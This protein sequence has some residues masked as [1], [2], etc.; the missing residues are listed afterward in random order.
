MPAPELNH[1]SLNDPGLNDPGLNNTPAAAF[2]AQ[3]LARMAKAQPIDTVKAAP[4]DISLLTRLWFHLR[5]HANQPL[6]AAH[7]N[8]NTLTA[9][10]A[11]HPAYAAALRD[12][13]V[14]LFATKQSTRL[15]TESGLLPY[16]SFSAALKR[17]IGFK[18]LPPELNPNHPRDW[19]DTHFIPRDSEWVSAAD[20]A[21]WARLCELLNL[22][23]LFQRD[24]PGVLV[25]AIRS[26]AHR[27]AAGGFDPELLRI[28]PA[29]EEYD[30][31]FLALHHEVDA[32]LRGEVNDTR[33]IDVLLEQCNAAL[34][35]VRRRKSELGASIELTNAN[36]CERFCL[37][38]NILIAYV[39]FY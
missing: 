27:I 6:A 16:R 39:S 14:S 13:L 32:W 11:V 26:L 17:R 25:N 7:A 34:D 33:Q 30:S 15:L 3:T 20:P 28:D 37:F 35:R 1:P 18:L 10:L 23:P 22:Q 4:A 24:P 9:I 29:L 31:P 21:V 12:H 38:D 36:V 5:P 19:L 8:L 2:I